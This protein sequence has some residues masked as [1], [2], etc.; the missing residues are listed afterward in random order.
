M[1]ASF[2]SPYHSRP[3]WQRIG[4]QIDAALQNLNVT[5]GVAGPAAAN[6]PSA[7][8]G[9]LIQDAAGTVTLDNLVVSGNRAQGGRTAFGGG[10]YFSGT[11]ALVSLSG[12]SGSRTVSRKC[13]PFFVDTPLR[14]LF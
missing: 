6:V 7:G 3:N 8:G 12:A 1:L 4:N 2:G 10:V 14:L 11:S 13:A 5:G 9:L